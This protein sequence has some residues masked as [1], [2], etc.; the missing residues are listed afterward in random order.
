[1]DLIISR[2]AGDIGF[3]YGSAS[4]A[5][6]AV[7]GGQA[8]SP[9]SGPCEDSQMALHGA[10]NACVCGGHVAMVDVS[11][12]VD[13]DGLVEAAAAIAELLVAE[14]CRCPDSHGYLQEA[15]EELRHVLAGAAAGFT[16]A[17]GRRLSTRAAASRLSGGS[18]RGGL[19][20]GGI[21]RQQAAA[22]K[23]HQQATCICA[24]TL[25]DNNDNRQR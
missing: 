16:A 22:A 3:A 14:P 15:L 21:S 10:A 18:F 11:D 4:A 20:A 13:E 6:S 5:L 8:A 2:Q 17:S 19:N 24:C 7:L 23:R 1:M 25:A 9:V 12:L